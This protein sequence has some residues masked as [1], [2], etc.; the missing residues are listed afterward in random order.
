M[1]TA[2]LTIATAVIPELPAL[3]T[4]IIAL[5]KKYPAMTPAQIT[6]AVQAASTQSDSAFS[7]AIA[8][9]QA[10]EAAPAAKKA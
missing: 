1:N 5:F 9:I 7:D 2:I 10:A 3:V 8:T 6:A 4:D